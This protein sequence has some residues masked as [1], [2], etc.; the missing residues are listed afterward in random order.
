MKPSDLSVLEKC[1]CLDFLPCFFN[2]AWELKCS[3]VEAAFSNTLQRATHG[4][5]KPTLTCKTSLNPSWLHAITALDFFQVTHQYLP[6][7]PLLP[8]PVLPAPESTSNELM[9]LTSIP[10]LSPGVFSQ[11][12]S[13]PKHSSLCSSIEEQRSQKRASFKGFY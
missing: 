1:C 5:T 10:L 9:P 7:K 2:K 4:P 8:Q 6:C 11:L 3:R 13:I 12:L